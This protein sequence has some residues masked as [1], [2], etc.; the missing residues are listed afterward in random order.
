MKKQLSKKLSE[1]S[2]LITLSVFAAVLYIS[3][4]KET[5]TPPQ[6]PCTPPVPRDLFADPIST[7]SAKLRATPVDSSVKMVFKYKPLADT[8]WFTA[9]PGNPIWIYSLVPDTDYEY[10]AVASCTEEHA[11]SSRSSDLAYFR[12][13][14]V[15][16][17]DCRV[18]PR[19][20]GCGA[21]CG[22]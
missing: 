1:L 11:P 16:Q 7:G 20:P 19:P 6:I 10:Y 14:K 9:D 2:L 8:T 21:A 18:R 12:T 15:Q 4:K 3:C 22:P 17:C 13:T 5:N